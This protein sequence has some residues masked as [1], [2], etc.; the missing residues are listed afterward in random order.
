M[1]QIFGVLPIQIHLRI[2]S[3][4]GS[5]NWWKDWVPLPPRPFSPQYHF[6]VMNSPP[7]GWFPT[8]G[9]SLCEDIDTGTEEM[10]WGR[11]AL[12]GCIYLSRLKQRGIEVYDRQ[13]TVAVHWLSP[14][15][16]KVEGSGVKLLPLQ[17]IINEPLSPLAWIFNSW[18]LSSSWKIIIIIILECER[19]LEFAACTRKSFTSSH[20]LAICL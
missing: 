5:I 10:V 3:I 18:S 11:D 9:E 2:Q 17:V 15:E 4:F 1:F 20:F 7:K 8:S 14:P 12:A 16:L 13:C 6:P 19:S